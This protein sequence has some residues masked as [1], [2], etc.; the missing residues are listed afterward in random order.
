MLRLV[1]EDFVHQILEDVY[2][3]G[4]PVRFIKNKFTGEIKIDANDCAR[5]IGYASI[6]DLLGTDK[7]LDAISDWK[8]D[9]PDKPVF[10]KHGSGAMFE[11][12]RFY[13]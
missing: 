9:N 13:Q 2:Y 6:H 10:G 7:G 3:D 4:T 5:C 11:E 8:K 12:A 1:S